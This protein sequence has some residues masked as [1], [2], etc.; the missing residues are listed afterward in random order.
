MITSR[1]GRLSRLFQAIGRH[2]APTPH[3]LAIMALLGVLG[4][5][6]IGSPR[7]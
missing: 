6:L 3:Q 2:D 5:P 4:G 7:A 1:Y